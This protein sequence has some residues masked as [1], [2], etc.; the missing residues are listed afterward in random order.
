MTTK[1]INI[2]VPVE[3][4]NDIDDMADAKHM[5]RTGYMLEAVKMKID[6][7]KFL[8]AKP[9][10]MQKLNELNDALAQVAKDADKDFAGIIGQERISYG[11]K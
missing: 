3:L 1:K 5:T 8:T 7:D 2:N 4:L 10:I 9:D 6:T 11:D